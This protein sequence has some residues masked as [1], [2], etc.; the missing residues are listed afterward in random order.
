M[1]N[2]Y[3]FLT[4]T[5]HPHYTYNMQFKALQITETPAGK[6]ERSIIQRSINDLPKGDVLI[7]VHY[8]ALNY[9]DGLSATGHKGIS[10][11]FPHTPGIEAAG[12][13]EVST[14]PQFKKGQ[15]VFLTGYDLGMNTSGAFAEYIRVPAEWVLNKPEGLSCKDIMTIGTAGFTAAY[16][17]YK[18]ELMGQSPDQGPIV[19]TGS[20][21]GVGSLSVAILAKAGYEVI[22][23]TGKKE[24]HDYL[25]YLGAARVESREFLNDTLGKPL[26]R[27]MWAGAIDTV[28]GNML[29]TLLK[30]CKRDG[31][32]VATGLL[33]SVHFATT[34]YPFILNGVNLL[35]IGAGQTPMSLRQS[36]WKKLEAEWNVCD[37]LPAI[38]SEIGL[39]ELKDTY[40]DA[41]LAGK[42]KGRVVVKLK[43][44][45]CA[46]E[47][48][49]VNLNTSR[50]SEAQENE[51]AVA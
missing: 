48:N 33:S 23:V 9:K 10:R 19:V 25:K 45:C 30:R 44:N 24:S 42:T 49:E 17:L 15:Q 12:Q 20:T 36:L 37:K 1:R 3:N 5:A 39:E 50:V 7:R 35:G 41:I 6:F 26:Q 28:S 2:G 18:M 32:V 4:A 38:V 46:T 43:E 29:T 21:G 40:I 27:A 22:A 11:N 31:N 13:V 8:S 34:I 14:V 16:A 51:I 47:N